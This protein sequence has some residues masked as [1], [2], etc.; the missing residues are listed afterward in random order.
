M[1]ALNMLK[2][3]LLATV[4]SLASGFSF[5]TTL[6][7]GLCHRIVGSL[8]SKNGKKPYLPTLES[9]AIEVC[10][11]KKIEDKKVC[12]GAI[13]SM[14][15]YIIAGLYK[16][17]TNPH[18]ICQNMKMCSDEYITRSLKVDVEKIIKDKPNK[19]WEKPSG[20]NILKVMHISDL[21]P[22]L[23][24]TEGTPVKCT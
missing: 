15:P 11:L 19:K 12:A 16:H 14:A 3:I 10:Y 8:Q 1:T 13:K 4:I 6:S 22:D 17:A 7:C 5:Q 24:Y 9:I 20:R 2:I 23:F 21:H 18:L